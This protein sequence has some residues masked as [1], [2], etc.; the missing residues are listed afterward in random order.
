MDGLVEKLKAKYKDGSKL[1]IR[2][3]SICNYP[4]GFSWLKGQL[5]YDTGCDCTGGAGGFQPRE[6]SEL[7]FY[8]NQPQW[9]E[10]FEAAVA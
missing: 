5:H 9:V 7:A 1:L 4:C 8:L 10:K 6:D 2:N 3:C